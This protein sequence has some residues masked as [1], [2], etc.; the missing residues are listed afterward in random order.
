V[1]DPDGV[2]HD[3]T[4][5]PVAEGERLDQIAAV[6]IGDRAAFWCGSATRTA[7]SGPTISKRPTA[8]PRMTLPTGVPAPE[9]EG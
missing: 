4:S 3:A 9:D 6:E 7:R 2:R 1:P 5:R 8:H